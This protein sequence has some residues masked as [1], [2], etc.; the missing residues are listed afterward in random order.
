VHVSF[1]IASLHSGEPVRDY[2][3]QESLGAV[4]V[5]QIEFI[6][7]PYS[8]DEWAALRAGK[9]RELEGRLIISGAP[10][11][12]RLPFALSGSGA[13]AAAQG[14]VMTSLAVFGIPAPIGGSAVLMKVDD[15]VELDYRV[16][17]SSL[18][19]KG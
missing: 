5:P 10:F 7:R 11:P 16:P 19:P 6:S 17:L 9:V 15:A 12:L 2:R 1:P 18:E 3:V 13:G 8:P 14:A 4:R